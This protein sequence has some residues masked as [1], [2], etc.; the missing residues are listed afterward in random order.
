MNLPA[1][2]V[3]GFVGGLSLYFFTLLG[4]Q[5]AANLSLFQEK[6]KSRAELEMIG[7][8]E[9]G[10]L[11]LEKY[12]IEYIYD[13]KETSMRKYTDEGKYKLGMTKFM[14]TRKNVKHELYHLLKDVEGEKNAK[15]N[16]PRYF[17]VQEPRATLY[18]IFGIKL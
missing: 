3:V 1:K 5:E 16:F 17:F 8:E 11:G 6:I 2:A 15:P 10:K 18:G 9:A 13:D 12:A 7:K 14:A 4:I